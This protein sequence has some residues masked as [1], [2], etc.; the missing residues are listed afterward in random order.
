M[1]EKLLKEIEGLKMQRIKVVKGK[2]A[3]PA[4]MFKLLSV[5]D[6]KIEKLNEDLHKLEIDSL[7]K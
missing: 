5:F 3:S 4:D 6:K 7:Q 1:K 2:H